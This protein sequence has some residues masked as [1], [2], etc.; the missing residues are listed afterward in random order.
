MTATAQPHRPLT[1]SA[2]AMNPT[3]PLPNDGSPD[4]WAENGTRADNVSADISEGAGPLS[5]WRITHVPFAAWLAALERWQLTGD[6]SE[7][8]FGNSQLLGPAEHDPHFSTCQIEVRLA[9]GG[10]RRP[11]HMR[12]EIDRWSAASTALTLIPCQR[13]RPGTAYFRA[14]RRLLDSLTCAVGAPVS[15]AAS[16][17]RE[18][19]VAAAVSSPVR[20]I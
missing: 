12:L 13:V 19:A 17:P 3:Q 1:R 7:L 14:G 8:S 5:F 16:S 18:Y 10:L 9:R 4:T 2:T 20:S 15:A 11:L 6:G